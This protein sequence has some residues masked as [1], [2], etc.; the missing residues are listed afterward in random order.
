[1]AFV[2]V[3]SDERERE[4]RFPTIGAIE[5]VRSGTI[6]AYDAKA[7]R[8]WRLSLPKEAEGPHGLSGAALEHAILALAATNPDLVQ[9]A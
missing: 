9:V 7:Y 1:M 4:S 8:S 2:D 6:L 5:A 3:R